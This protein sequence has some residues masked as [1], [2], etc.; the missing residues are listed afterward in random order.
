M[1]DGTFDKERFLSGDYVLVE[2]SSGAEY[3]D[4]ETQPTYAVGDRVELGGKEYEVM[5]IVKNIRASLLI[6]Y[7]SSAGS[8]S[9]HRL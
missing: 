3:G 8:L 5:G 1:I 4:S 6:P 2:A 9:S 7:S